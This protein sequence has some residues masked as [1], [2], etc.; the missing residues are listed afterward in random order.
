M[1]SNDD[2]E[3]MKKKSFV[4]QHFFFSLIKPGEFSESHY[5]NSSAGTEGDYSAFFKN[6]F[7]MYAYSQLK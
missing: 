5:P 3:K 2:K 1:Y 7:L 4:G 6:A